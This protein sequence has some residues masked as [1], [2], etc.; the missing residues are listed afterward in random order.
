MR[1]LLVPWLFSATEDQ[2]SRTPIGVAEAHHRVNSVG[3]PERGRNQSLAPI[4]IP[5]NLLGFADAGIGLPSGYLQAVL[6]PD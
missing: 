3:C 2:Y 4:G 1:N 5:P 6:G